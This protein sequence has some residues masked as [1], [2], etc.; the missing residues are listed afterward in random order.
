[1]LA[2]LR[3][4]EPVPPGLADAF[5]HLADAATYLAR[6]LDRLVE[7][8]AARE[9]ALD[10]VRAAATA[11]EDGVGFSGSS[12]VAQVR[13]TALDLLLATGQAE[14]DARDAVRTL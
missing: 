14:S 7:P 3:D 10:A 4:Q 1:V 2:L 11:Y 13:S 12:V 8:A 5:D 6:D 9:A